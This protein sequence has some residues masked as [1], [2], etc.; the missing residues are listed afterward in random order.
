MSPLLDIPRKKFY[1]TFSSVDNSITV[2]LCECLV[3]QGLTERL[4]N[5]IRGL[6]VCVKMITHQAME[7]FWEIYKTYSAAI[8]WDFQMSERFITFPY[9]R[10]VHVQKYH[11]KHE[12]SEGTR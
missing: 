10:D 7:N 12:K 5:Y 9:E 8:D 2:L 1:Q 3:L 11:I 6:F 4:T